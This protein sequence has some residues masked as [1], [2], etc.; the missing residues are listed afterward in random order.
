MRV[1]IFHRRIL[2][3][4]LQKKA[5]INT[6][7]SVEIINPK[8]PKGNPNCNHNNNSTFY[9]KNGKSGDGGSKFDESN[10]KKKEDIIRRLFFNG[11]SVAAEKLQE[12][13]AI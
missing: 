10:N 7:S 4:G 2:V 3:F 9:K 5:S 1:C 12:S 6:S 11:A 13:L 8:K